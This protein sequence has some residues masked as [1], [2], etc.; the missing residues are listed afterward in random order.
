MATPVASRVRM[1]EPKG[2]SSSRRGLSRGKG[3]EAVRKAFSRLFN[4]EMLDDPDAPTM[5]M[6]LAQYPCRRSPNSA[7]FPAW[8]VLSSNRGPGTSLTGVISI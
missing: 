6:I 5:L 7:A 3:V 1:R 8:A 2:M 4:D